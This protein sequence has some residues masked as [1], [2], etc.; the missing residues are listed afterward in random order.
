[1]DREAWHA[2]VHGIAESV[3]IERTE[4]TEQSRS[5]MWG[6]ILKWISDF[7]KA[8]KVHCVLT[9]EVPGGC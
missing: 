6:R 1:M 2:A 8:P 5:Q 7:L 9:R 3:R 4:R